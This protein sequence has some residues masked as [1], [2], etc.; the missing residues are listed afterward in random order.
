MDPGTGNAATHHVVQ[1]LSPLFPSVDP[2]VVNRVVLDS[3]RLYVD[4]PN[5][6]S[7]PVLVE[8]TSR[9]RLRGHLEACS[10]RVG[11]RL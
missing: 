9:D 2:V 11:S 7:V 10:I 1:R 6:N 4:H 3:Y 5:P 8:E